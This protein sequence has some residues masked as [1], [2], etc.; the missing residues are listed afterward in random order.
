MFVFGQMIKS[1]SLKTPMGV[2]IGFLAVK[3]NLKSNQGVKIYVKS[4]HDQIKSC[5]FLVKSSNQIIKSKSLN[6][7]MGVQ[8]SFLAIKSNQGVEN[9]VKSNHDQIKSCLYLVKSSNQIISRSVESS[10]KK[11]THII[12]HT[13]FDQWNPVFSCYI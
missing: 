6:T 1:N 2:Q 8:I 11:M 5:L 3:S 7:P 13:Y 12:I 4:N 10:K 9:Y